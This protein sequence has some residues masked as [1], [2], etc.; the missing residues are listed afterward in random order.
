[1]K[2][3]GLILLLIS[4]CC[5]SKK[6]PLRIY[7]IDKPEVQ[8]EVEN[9][10][11]VQ[12]MLSFRPTQ[13]PLFVYLQKENFMKQVSRFFQEMNIFRNLWIIP[14]ELFLYKVANIHLT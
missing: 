8:K 1:M 12:G 7:Q 9:K 2:N 3:I 14:E 10:S 5:C 11:W 13:P 4:L 6:R